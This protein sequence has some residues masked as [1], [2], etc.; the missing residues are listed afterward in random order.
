MSPITL[1]FRHSALTHEPVQLSPP[2]IWAVAR[3]LRAQLTDDPLQRKLDLSKIDEQGARLDVN[4][5]RFGVLW[6][7]DHA[8]RNADGEEV[9][10]V[11]EYAETTPLHVLV[12]INGPRLQVSDTLLRSTIAHEL[13]HV[14]FDAPSWMVSRQAPYMQAA[15]TGSPTVSARWD[16]MEVRANEFM[17]A[18]L[19]P[20]API[21][22][23]FLRLVKRQRLSLSPR[24][25]QVIPG[26]PAVDGQTVEAEAAAEMLFSLGQLYGVSESFMRVRLSRYD[27]LR[28]ARPI[29]LH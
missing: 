29:T 26:A 25:S 12:S 21:R 20:P 2:E 1:R 14:I 13:G 7:F 6:D 11:T 17:G 16:P 9:L 3:N 8:V 18:L 15:S 19:V 4:D 5:I 27:L 10:G 24:P 28:T 23:D 22:I